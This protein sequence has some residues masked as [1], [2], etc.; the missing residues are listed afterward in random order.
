MN[1]TIQS[2]VIPNGITVIGENA[3]LSCGNLKSIVLPDSLKEIELWA[4]GYCSSLRTMIIPNGTERIGRC[5]FYLC[6]AITVWIP[7]SVTTI[8][9]QVFTS[10]EF[11]ILTEWES[12]PDGWRE[13]WIEKDNMVAWGIDKSQIKK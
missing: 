3:F 2:V 5:A 6:S 13:S 10:G 4:F 8:E 11:H 1:C 9:D 12:K 7:Q